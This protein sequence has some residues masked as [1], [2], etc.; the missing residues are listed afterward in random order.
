MKIL[1]YM[2]I[3][4]TVG[5][6]TIATPSKAQTT[7]PKTIKQ[8]TF[9]KSINVPPS[10]TKSDSVLLFAPNPEVYI[11]GELKTATI[12]VD[13]SRNVL[14][15]YDEDGNAQC[16]YLV[17]SGKKNTPTDKGVRVVSH[18]EKYPYKTAPITT[19]RRKNPRDYGPRA[20]I[21]DKLDP[22]TGKRSYFGE[23]IHGN[24]NPAS[25]GK[26]ASLGCIRMDNE[27][28]KDLSSKVK[29]G[30]IVVIK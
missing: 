15:H 3:L 26:Y 28:I 22:E 4:S 23:F 7:T 6:L 1:P 30:D 12:V 24:K 8:D 18:V 29:R 19:K 21:L 2:G 10:G 14:Y 5:V 27:V 11:K 17:A 9:E 13:L 16:A 20:I 25:I